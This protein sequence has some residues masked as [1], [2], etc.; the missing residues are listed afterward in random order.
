[1]ICTARVHGAEDALAWIGAALSQGAGWLAIPSHCLDE[2]FF[3]LRSDI[4]GEIVQKFVT[5]RVRLAIGGDISRHTAASEVLRNFIYESNR[6]SAG[7][8][9]GELRT[10]RRALVHHAERYVRFIVSQ[11]EPNR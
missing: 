6:G 10:A 2:D 8:V 11:K 5:Y 4:A 1:M 7:L 9:R 3:R